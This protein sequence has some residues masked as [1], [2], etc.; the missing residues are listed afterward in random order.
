MHTKTTGKYHLKPVRITIIKE[1]LQIINAGEV[2][3]KGEPWYTV[4]GNVNLYSHC[5]EQQR[6]SL[7]N[8]E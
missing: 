3:E 6:D 5:R 8:Q 4:G 7:R 2:V 1:N